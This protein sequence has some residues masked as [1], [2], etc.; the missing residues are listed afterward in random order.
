M[1]S[2]YFDSSFKN[3]LPDYMV[4]HNFSYFEVCDSKDKVLISCPLGLDS[5]AASEFLAETL[6]GFVEGEFSVNLYESAKKKSICSVYPFKLTSVISGFNQSHISTDDKLAYERRI[7]ELENQQK[8]EGLVKGFNEKLQALEKPQGTIMGYLDNLQVIIDRFPIIGAIMEGMA[9]KYL[10]PQQAAAIN[11]VNDTDQDFINFI[12]AC[13]GIENAKML[14]KVA[15]PH[16]VKHKMAFISDL[17]N[18][19]NNYGK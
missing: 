8:I 2:A 12:N 1:A 7:W 4:T 11:G 10:A 17:H 13:G 9:A 19:I 16:I 15:T 14:L 5:K 18:F 6:G 3:K